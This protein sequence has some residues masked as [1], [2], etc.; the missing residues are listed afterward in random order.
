MVGTLTLKKGG[1]EKMQKII[2][3]NGL[4]LIRFIIPAFPEVNVFSWAA[5]RTTALGPIMVATAA[6][7]AWGWQVEVIDENNYNG[8]RNSRGLPD[9]R[10]L[11]KRNKAEVVGF[12]CGLSSTMER[13]WELAGFYHNEGVVTV[14]GGWHAHY[15]PRETLEKN[16]DIVVH[17]DGE[18]AILNILNSLK[19]RKYIGN[20]PGISFLEDGKMKTNPPEMLE[21]TSLNDLPYPDFGLLKYAKMKTFP[22][23]RT[24]GCR[25]NC[26]FCSVRGKPRWS[27]GQY[28]FEVVNWLVETRKARYFFI[29]DDRLEENLT[30]TLDF[31]KMVSAKYGTRLNFTVQVRLEAAENR[32]LPE[33]MWKAGVRTVAIGYES[34]IDEEL[35]AMRKGYS[36]SQMLEWTKIW[37][38]YFGILAMFIFGYP[39]KHKKTSITPEER[40][41]YFKIFIQKACFYAVQILKAIPLVGTDLRK[42]LEQEG[43]IYPLEL[44]PWSKYD[45]NFICFQPDNMSSQEFQ[46]I[47]IKLMKWFYTPLKIFKILLRTLAF[48]IDCFIKGWRLS[49]R[50]W[51]KEIIGFGGHFL[52]RK[53]QQRE[54][55]KLFIEK[56]EQHQ[57]SQKSS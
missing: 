42:R 37:R 43:R 12:Y 13:V 8:P 48:P 31:F 19:K 45:G 54:N 52:I 46:E 20:T 49:C 55:I 38:K 21:V 25:M 51:F 41:N 15:C 14:A 40:Y 50:D 1:R 10:I 27:T 32:E 17:G 26:E 29:V 18:I 24:R 34:P 23:G 44:V 39:L 4:F 57:L 53:W 5:R 16:I 56:L 11:Q 36:S 7:K 47:P 28:L 35:I 3:R 6:N 2:N 9:H 22:V 30:G 33:T